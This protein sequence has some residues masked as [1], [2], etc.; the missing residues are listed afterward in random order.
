MKAVSI[1]TRAE[2]KKEEIVSFHPIRT[3]LSSLG[4]VSS[5]KI[6]K[7]TTIPRKTLHKRISRMVK[8]VLKI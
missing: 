7:P 4:Q 8:D 1:L 3:R 2:F 5:Q 6:S